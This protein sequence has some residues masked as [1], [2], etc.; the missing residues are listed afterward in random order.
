MNSQ[1]RNATHRLQRWL[2]HFPFF[3]VTLGHFPVRA[4]RFFMPIPCAGQCFLQR[5]LSE[6]R[7]GSSLTYAKLEAPLRAAQRTHGPLL[8]SPEGASMPSSTRECLSAPGLPG[9]SGQLASGEHNQADSTN[10]DGNSSRQQRRKVK[11]GSFKAARRGLSVLQQAT[12][13][14]V[15]AAKT[16]GWMHEHQEQQRRH[17][18]HTYD[19]LNDVHGHLRVIASITAF[20]VIQ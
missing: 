11:R 14:S 16:Q 8:A 4:W 19:P 5:V 18:Q 6:K 13:V 15:C 9:L 12:A 3:A 2:C 1:H 17:T 10:D 7:L 20:F